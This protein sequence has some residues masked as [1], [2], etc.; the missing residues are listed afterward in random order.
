[1]LIAAESR[2]F[3]IWFIGGKTG[4]QHLSRAQQL[5]G[6]PGRDNKTFPIIGDNGNR[7]VA[8]IGHTDTWIGSRLINT[9]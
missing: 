8:T 4:C 2:C 9:H 6:V 7:L 3:N 5:M 1:M